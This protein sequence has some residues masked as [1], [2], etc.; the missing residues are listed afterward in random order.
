MKQTIICFLISIFSVISQAETET[1]QLSWSFLPFGIQVSQL[2]ASDAVTEYQRASTLTLLKD[3]S[4][5]NLGS[6]IQWNQVQSQSGN[7]KIQSKY[8][9]L[10]LVGNRTLFQFAQAETHGLS[11]YVSAGLGLL[12]SEISTDFGS[13]KKSVMSDPELV[14]FFGLGFQAI[15]LKTS[16]NPAVIQAELRLHQESALSKSSF[17]SG[18]LKIGFQF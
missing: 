6:E 15:A 14:G 16:K 2:A 10:F 11:Q 5:L 7:L 18:S 17:I 9:K 1:K 4:F 8:Q 12:R 3:L 13:S